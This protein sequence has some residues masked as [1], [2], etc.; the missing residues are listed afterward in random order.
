MGGKNEIT[1]KGENVPLQLCLLT[2]FRPA[3]IKIRLGWNLRQE[4]MCTQPCVN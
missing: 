3:P 4:E 1:S 2:V